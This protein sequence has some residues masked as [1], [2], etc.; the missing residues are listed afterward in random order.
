ME[1]I[2]NPIENEIKVVDDIFPNSYLSFLWEYAIKSRFV[3]GRTSSYMNNRYSGNSQRFTCN[4]TKQDL[5]NT[6]LIPYLQKITNELSIQNLFLN[7]YYISHCSKSTTSDSHVDYH[8]ANTITF[9]I[10]PNL[11]WDDMWAGDIKFYSENS[12]IDKSISVKPGRVIIFDSRIKHKV[13]PL[14]YFAEI[15]RFS[16]VINAT[17]FPTQMESTIHITN[18]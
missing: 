18:A 16:F 8:D 13:M 7:R 3:W 12:A 11:E 5:F 1:E 9:L 6:G 2:I 17:L 4:L 10:Y 14:S 15:D